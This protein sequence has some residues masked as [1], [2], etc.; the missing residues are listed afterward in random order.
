MMAAAIDSINQAESPEARTYRRRV[1]A[2]ALYDV[3]DHAFITSTSTTFFPPYF[4]AIA[5]T[6]FLEAGKTVN[7]PAAVTAAHINASNI[8]ALCVSIALFIS[9]LV[10]PVLGAYADITGQR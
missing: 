8:F 7:D 9:A 10:A 4:A 1:W 2:W 6:A 5:V 3:A